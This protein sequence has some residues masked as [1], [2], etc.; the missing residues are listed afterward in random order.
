MQ[1]LNVWG[2]QMGAETPPGGTTGAK[3]GSPAASDSD[4]TLIDPA[5]Q[6][7]LR[8]AAMAGSDKTVSDPDAQALL[9]ASGHISA[10]DSDKTLASPVAKSGSRASDARAEIESRNPPA[11]ARE[12]GFHGSISLATRQAGGASQA[13][14]APLPAAD[15]LALPVGFKLFEYQV[16]NVLG[17]GG[18]GSR[19]VH[20]CSSLF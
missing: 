15:S 7:R 6:E 5:A 1:G 8:K 12:T 10:A 4:K 19:Y 11:R 2:N 16:D 17:Q 9:Q 18:F 13:V 14:Y 3:G 20:W